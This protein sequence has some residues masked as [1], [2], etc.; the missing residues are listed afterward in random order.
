MGQSTTPRPV[1][2]MCKESGIHPTTQDCIDGLRA[3]IDQ[4]STLKA[5]STDASIQHLGRF[6]PSFYP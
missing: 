1:C 2:P 6:V 5:R 4:L 3:L